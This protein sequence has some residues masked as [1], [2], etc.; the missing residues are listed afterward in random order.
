MPG[1]G[2][3]NGLEFIPEL[4]VGSKPR[5]GFSPWPWFMAVSGLTPGLGFLYVCG[6]MTGLGF[7]AWDRV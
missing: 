4:G 5:L 2:F 7:T 1:L 3:G 6:L